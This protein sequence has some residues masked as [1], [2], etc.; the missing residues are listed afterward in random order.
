MI[1]AYRLFGRHGWVFHFVSI[2]PYTVV[3]IFSLTVIW[4]RFGKEASFLMVT[5]SSLITSAVIYNVEARMYSMAAMFVL[6]AYYGLFLIIN[7]SSKKEHNKKEKTGYILFVIASL[8]A[9]YSHYYS[10]LVVAFFYLALLVL[11]FTKKLELQKILLT[12]FITIIGYIPWL[13]KMLNTLKKTADN[14]WMTSIPTF[15]E[16]MLYFYKSEKMWYSGGMIFLT[17]II[18]V[19]LF[20][21]DKNIVVLKKNYVSKNIN[22]IEL[23]INGSSKKASKETVWL[24][25]GLVA[26]IGTLGI[27]EVVSI[28]VR[29][30]FTFRYLYVTVPVIWIVLSVGI[31]RLKF[32]KFLAIVIVIITLVVCLPEYVTLYQS[33]KEA[34]KLCDNTAEI[35]QEHM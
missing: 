3:L 32:K 15:G 12:Y 23:F 31:T 8:G 27:G 11:V 6:L 16:C 35:M 7:R 24:I 18:V 13:F 34:G 26:A 20:I 21:S 33:E 17:F 29:P 25:W 4:K 14:F 9:A 5:F 2:I 28:M 30:V 19:F 1:L 10:L 22:K